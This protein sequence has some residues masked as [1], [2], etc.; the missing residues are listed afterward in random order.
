MHCVST[1]EKNKFGP[2]SKNLLS[3]IRGFKSA[4][5]TSIRKTGH[6]AFAWQPRYYDHIIRDMADYKRIENYIINNPKKWE[7]DW[8]VDKRIAGT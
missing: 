5:T 8:F 2:Q 7:L 4:V 3:I 6:N 1:K